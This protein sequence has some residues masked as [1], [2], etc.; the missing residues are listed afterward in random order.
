MKFLLFII[1][2]ITYIPRSSYAMDDDLKEIHK[3]M[4]E[5]A[6]QN[7]L[8]QGKCRALLKVPNLSDKCS[9]YTTDKFSCDSFPSDLK[10][11]DYCPEIG[12]PCTKRQMNRFMCKCARNHN[13]CE[14]TCIATAFNDTSDECSDAAT[15][16]CPASFPEERTFEN[17]CPEIKIFCSD[18]Q[19][20]CSCAN[21][22]N[23]CGKTCAKLVDHETCG[24]KALDRAC[25]ESFPK[26]KTY[27]DHCEEVGFK[28][29]NKCKDK[30]WNKTK[31][32]GVQGCWWVD[33][34]PKRRCELQDDNGTIA[35]EACFN[36]CNTCAADDITI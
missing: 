25:G 7:E 32:K 36:A 21:R 1:V 19:S 12:V 33:K 34:K 22:F 10:Y 5:C 31:N 26:D 28:C 18:S 3:E 16:I 4:C 20:M 35:K 8:C 15:Q 30:H 2:L 11:I 14:K 9:K 29:N 6:R 13:L 23:S 27:V 17:Y 24:N